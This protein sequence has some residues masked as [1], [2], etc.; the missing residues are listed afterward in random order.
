M[1][2]LREDEAVAWLERY[3]EAW[4]QRDVELIAGIFAQDATY[5]ETPYTSP[6]EGRAGVR[7]YW[8]RN[9]VRNQ[10]DIA[11]SYE[12][13]PVH[14]NVCIA[15]WHSAFTVI[16]TDTR[17]HLDGVFHLSFARD[18]TGAPVCTRLDEW[19]HAKRTPAG[20]SVP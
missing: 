3:K 11:F 8:R 12:I 5:R 6:D 10:R 18:G 4:E 14:A 16:E 17:V 19:W 7:N 1:T 20:K 9:V 13:W 2:P 15:H